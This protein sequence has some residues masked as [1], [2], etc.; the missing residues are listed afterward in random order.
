VSIQQS[1]ETSGKIASPVKKLF[2]FLFALLVAS[3]VIAQEPSSPDAPPSA[4]DQPGPWEPLGPIPVDQAG[5][6]RRGYAVA[7]ESAAVAEPGAG[8]LSL[9]AVAA[10]NF[11]REETDRFAISQRA[12]THSLALEYRRGF[13]LGRLPRV[14]LGG[15]VQ[16]HE[17]D[18]GFLNG[19][20]SGFENLW[21][22]ATG[23]KSAKNQLRTDATLPA[24][25]V[26][27]QG[28]QLLYQAPG[29][30]SAF[31]DLRL[32]AKTL[33]HD[34]VAARF[35]LN[36]SGRSGFTD[37]N[38]A[39]FGLSIEKRLTSWAVFH[40]DA[41]T[42]LLVDRISDWNLP[43]KRATFGFS[44]SPE[45]KLT[46]NSSFNLQFDG[47]TTPYL[48]TGS[49]VFD[50]GYGAL[51]IGVS[52]RIRAGQT[53]LLVQAYARENMNLPFRVRWNTDPDLA[54][55]LKITINTRRTRRLDSS[56]ATAPQ[57]P[58]TR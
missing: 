11:Y 45:L 18:S 17:R 52:H 23:A 36:V 13:T 25:T 30:G 19:F 5:A 4:V 58:P 34:R 31:G 3:P 16:L 48:P 32:V 12:E 26:M 55:G 39:G 24:G 41:R 33:V 20:I 21:V 57:A 50:K 43:L 49:S 54:V 28:D 37:G 51:T 6:G 46:T 8:T 27:K 35:V 56:T 47:N 15:Q 2:V 14:E 38:F 7:S 44:A 29:N 40:G 42:T 9:H 10:N 22:S 1:F 53:P